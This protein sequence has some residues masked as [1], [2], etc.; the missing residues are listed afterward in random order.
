[1]NDKL[2]RKIMIEFVAQRA[3]IYT[4]KQ[5]DAEMPEDWQCKGIKECVV[6]KTMMI[7]NYNKLIYDGLNVC[8][9]S[10]LFLKN[11]NEIYTSKVNK[12]ASDDQRGHY[13]S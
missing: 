10:M 8:R 5:M 6:K 9:E 2:G 1:M 4:Y 7:N 12:I 3:R 13:A 11:I